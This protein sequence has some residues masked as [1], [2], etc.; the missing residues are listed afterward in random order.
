MFGLEAVFNV[1]KVAVVLKRFP[2]NPECQMWHK[3]SLSLPGQNQ[4]KV[5]FLA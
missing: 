2:K 4:R 1:I 5:Y 3:N